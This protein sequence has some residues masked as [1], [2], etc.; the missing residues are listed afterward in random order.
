MR[1][2]V[3]A[4]IVRF[5]VAAHPERICPY[6]RCPQV[7]FVAVRADGSKCR[8]NGL[9]KTDADRARECDQQD[10]CL[11]FRL[12]AGWEVRGRWEAFQHRVFVD[13]IDDFRQS[14]RSERPSDFH[15]AAQDGGRKIFAWTLSAELQDSFTDG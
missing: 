3:G 4:E 1:D 5:S 2:I 8:F 7:H 14:C 10:K 6:Q 12:A 11:A 15:W 9:D 13:L